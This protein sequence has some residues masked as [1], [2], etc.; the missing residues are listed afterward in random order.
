MFLAWNFFSAAVHAF[1]PR[2]YNYNCN[3]IIILLVLWLLQSQR[4]DQTKFKHSPYIESITVKKEMLQYNN[5]C[6]ANI[7]Q[8]FFLIIPILQIKTLRYG[9]KV[10]WCARGH[11]ASELLKEGFK[12]KSVGTQASFFLPTPLLPHPSKPKQILFLSLESA[13]LLWKDQQR[14]SKMLLWNITNMFLKIKNYIC[15]KHRTAYVWVLKKK[16]KSFKI[17]SYQLE[18]T[19][20]EPLESNFKAIN[21]TVHCYKCLISL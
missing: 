13:I 14:I 20:P 12:P 3:H 10:M 9:G 5:N 11:S 7:L 2:T 21:L 4:W 15:R 18:H 17:I 16:K 1:L 8:T 19:C 6:M